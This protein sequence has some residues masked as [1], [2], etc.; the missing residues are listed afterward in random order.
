MFTHLIKRTL[1]GQPRVAFNNLRLLSVSHPLLGEVAPELR[2]RIQKLIDSNDIVLFMKG[3]P[4][5]PMCGF[6]RNAK[7]VSYI[8]F[9]IL[10]FTF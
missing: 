3:T 10:F 9:R 7:K 4:E 2:S 1:I 5:Q 6:S 8:D